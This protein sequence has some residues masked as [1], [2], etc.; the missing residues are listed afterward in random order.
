MNWTTLF[1]MQKKLDDYIAKSHSLVDEDLFDQ[2]V[3]ALIVELSELANETRSFKFWSMNQSGDREQIVEEFVDG[4]HFML[5]VRLMFLLNLVD[6]YLVM[7]CVLECFYKLY[8]LPLLLASFFVIL[9]LQ[10]HLG[11]DNQQQ[12]SF[13]FP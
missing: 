10:Q 4:I 13:D 1:S 9:L 2:K 7:L 12:L 8:I 5:S 6:P 11:P 3:L